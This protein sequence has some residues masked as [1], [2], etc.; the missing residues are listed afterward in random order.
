[1]ERNFN[2]LN[3]KRTLNYNGSLR[4]F[5]HETH[6]WRTPSSFVSWACVNILF[7]LG[8]T[9]YSCLTPSLPGIGFRS[10]TTLTRIEYFLKM[11]RPLSETRYC[12]IRHASWL[13]KHSEVY[14]FSKQAKFVFYNVMLCGWVSYYQNGLFSK[15]SESI[16]CFR[17]WEGIITPRSSFFAEIIPSQLSR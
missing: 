14:H 6:I 3:A 5:S 15:Q 12:D 9:T 7:R 11:Y 8:T 4:A 16:C 13:Q 17:Q 1:M 2:T 10:T